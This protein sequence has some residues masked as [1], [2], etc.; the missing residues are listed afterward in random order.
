MYEIGRFDDAD[1]VLASAKT[2][3]QVKSLRD[4][5]EAARIYARAANLGLE[6]QN[7]AA[8]MRLRA[9]RKAGQLLSEM[10]L[11][12]GG[13]PSLKLPSPAST[14]LSELGITKSQSSRWQKRASVPDDAFQDYLRQA[15]ANGEEI[16]AAGLLRAVDPECNLSRS[17]YAVPLTSVERF[18]M[19]ADGCVDSRTRLQELSNHFETLERILSPLTEEETTRLRRA[20]CRRISQILCDVS[21]LLSDLVEESPERRT[22]RPKTS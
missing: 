16:S 19:P 20:E 18:D 15:K 14:G 17:R 7:R 9:E 11:P 12:K 10:A 6:M 8:E 2:I 13:R 5:A 3:E 1:K 22:I 21:G 4:T